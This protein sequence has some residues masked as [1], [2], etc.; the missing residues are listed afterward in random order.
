MISIPT[1]YE[2][3]SPGPVLQFRRPG[4][5]GRITRFYSRG[6]VRTV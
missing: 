1:L 5:K 3:L 2:T 4:K 6:L